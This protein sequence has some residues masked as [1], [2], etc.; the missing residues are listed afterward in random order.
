MVDR[1]TKALLLAI[2]IGLWL[3]VAGDWIRPAVVQAQQDTRI[4]ERIRS[5]LSSIS[6]GVCLNS[7]IC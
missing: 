3:N 1:T 4:L 7:K 2:A 5:D 6:I